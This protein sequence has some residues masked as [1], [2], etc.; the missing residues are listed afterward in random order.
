MLK[1]FILI[2]VW[3][4]CSNVKKTQTCFLLKRVKL[5]RILKILSRQASHTTT[6][7]RPGVHHLRAVSVCVGW[8]C[9]YT[10]RLQTTL[11][12]AATAFFHFSPSFKLRNTVPIP[13]FSIAHR[14]KWQNLRI[15]KWCWRNVCT[16]F[17]SIGTV[18]RVLLGSR[19]GGLLG[20][21]VTTGLIVP[22]TLRATSCSALC[23]LLPRKIHLAKPQDSSQS[24]TLRS[25]IK[26][27][28]P[29]Y[30]HIATN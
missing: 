19:G 3:F 4:K 24:T 25:K 22:W 29:S 13:C 23:L 14:R 20:V 10:V 30:P 8:V 16:N 7:C 1:V 18:A 21:L 11:D 28:N 27:Q 6:L 17:S 26:T 2:L 12:R 15:H 9:C 5:R